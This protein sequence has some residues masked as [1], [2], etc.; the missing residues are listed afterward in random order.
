MDIRNITKAAQNALTM[1]PDR[2]RMFFLS[3]V[4]PEVMKRRSNN[5]AMLPAKSGETDAGKGGE[6]HENADNG[7]DA[8]SA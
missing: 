2:S 8:G 4:L 6:P 1:T 3:R 7:A 5:V